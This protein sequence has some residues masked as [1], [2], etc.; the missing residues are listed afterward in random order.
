MIRNMHG[1]TCAVSAGTSGIRQ[2]Q[3]QNSPARNRSLRSRE[4]QTA[5]SKASSNTD[6]PAHTDNNH[7]ERILCGQPPQ[8]TASDGFDSDRV[9]PL[10]ARQRGERR[11]LMFTHEHTGLRHAMRDSR[12]LAL[13][14]TGQD[15]PVA[16]LCAG[17]LID[18]EG[19]I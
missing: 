7:F 9:R 13:N 15:C 6:A 4:R 18:L 2:G 5:S 3:Q 16:D 11:G 8:R 10:H 14:P 19:A 17:G 1:T 12:E